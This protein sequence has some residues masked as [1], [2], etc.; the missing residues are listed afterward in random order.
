MRFLLPFC[1]ALAALSLVL[2]PAAP[3][4]DPLMWLLWGREIAAGGLDTTGGPAFKP[5]PVA[6]CALLAALG[7][8]APDAWLI[9]ARAGGI[10][11]VALAGVLAYRLAR[12][13]APPA[14]IGPALAGAC[15]AVGI[16]LLGSLAGL[17]AAGAVEGLCTALAL[18]AVMAWRSQRP[19]LA[20][21]LALCCALIRIEAVP[22]LLVGA[23]AAW[24]QRSDLR[25]AIIAGA[26]ALPALWLLPD[27]VSSGDV[28]RSAARARIPNP[29]QPALAP[30][31]SLA[32][33]GGGAGLILAPVALG[34]LFLSPRRDRGAA[35]LALAGAAWLGLVAAMAQLG[36]SG[37]A[38]YAVVG[39]AAVTVAGAAGLARLARLRRWA[40]VAVGIA[41]LAAATPRMAGLERDG[42]RLA[43]GLRRSAGRERAIGLAGG[44]DAL[45]DCGAPV[46]GRYR[47]PLLAY[48]L[49]IPKQRVI[50]EAPPTGVT[51][52]SRLSSE[53][54]ATP[55]VVPRYR[56]L[57]RTA[58]WRVAARCRP[59]SR[60]Q[61]AG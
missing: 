11:A 4:Y 15:A 45:L 21:A 48:R 35:L 8:R 22:F 25:P 57:A 13:G 7:D 18:G 9:V 42:E 2:V 52:A 53:P 37:E 58:T 59:G 41:V 10:A 14:R 23:A 28:L 12:E 20:L 27:L 30:I 44:R 3:G 26:L 31:P 55:A 29:G 6:V 16:A 46:V 47:G 32:S 34:V 61:G 1:I 36:F 33:L 39:A 38:R 5:L 40:P 24:R 43:H 17:S 51:F 19:G 56:A 49:G 60:G 54:V 50:F